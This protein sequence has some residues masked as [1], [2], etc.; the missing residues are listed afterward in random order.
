MK[1][2]TKR[3]VIGLLGI[4]FLLSLVLV[5]GMEV[6]RRR[7]EAGLSSAHIAVPVNSKSCVDCHGQP[8]QSPGIV[9][10]WKGSTHAVKG[11]GCV[12]CHLAQKGDVDGFDHYGAHIATVV[13][14]KDCSR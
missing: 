3:T 11:V 12:E 5:Q 1:L 10:H 7:E 13:T 4:L 9:D 14:P 8:T 6:A 2:Q